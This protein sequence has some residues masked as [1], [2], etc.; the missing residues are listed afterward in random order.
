MTAK[1]FTRREFLTRAPAS[2]AAVGLAGCGGSRPEENAK[3]APGGMWEKPP[4]QRDKGNRLNLILLDVDT[5]RADNLACYGGSQVD[6]PNLNAF[7]RDS[8]IF[9]EAYPEAL[10]T[11]PI[12]RNLMTGRRILPFDYYQQHDPV[13]M[14]GWHQLFF[15]DVTLA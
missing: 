10:P 13:Q 11:L 6:C 7:A 12:R 4:D 5:F 2:A 3:D 8:V 14:P 1:H 9:E 15:E